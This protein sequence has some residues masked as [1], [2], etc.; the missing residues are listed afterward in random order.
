MA[1]VL[2]SAQYLMTLNSNRGLVGDST[3]GTKSAGNLPITERAQQF[4]NTTNSNA[5]GAI[6]Q[7][8]FGLTSQSSTGGFDMSADSRVI[9]T[10]VQYNAP[11]RIQSA[12]MANNGAS[13]DVVSGTNENNFKRF[14]IGGNDT[15]FCSA[16]AGAN[17]ICIDPTS[18]SN[19][20]SGGTFDDTN[21]SGWG[22][23]CVRFNV[24]GSSSLH[25]FFQRVFL[26]Q[27][28]KD[29][30]DIPK[31][32]GTGSDWDEAFT[33]VQGSSYTTTIGKW[34][35]KVGSAFFVPC[36]FQF[37]DGSTATTF[38]DGGATIVSPADNATDAENFRLTN[39]SMRVYAS[40]RNNA[41]DVLTL[42]GTYVWGT[43]SPWDFDQNDAAVINLDGATFSGMGNF[44]LGSSVSGAATFNLDS[45]SFVRSRGANLDGSQVN[46]NLDLLG[47]SATDLTNL[48][49]TGIL[50]F[51]TAGTYNL[52]ACTINEVTNSS[53]GSVILNLSNGS[54]ITTNTGPSITANNTVSLSFSNIV[55]GSRLYV[56][57]T[58]TV[59]VVTTGDVLVN[60]IVTTD[61]FV[62]AHNFEGDLSFVY[63]VRSAS[64]APYYQPVQATGTIRT[65]GF[66]AV[67]QQI[68]DE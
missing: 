25:C 56:Q 38:D 16:Q 60:Q 59:G 64:T 2:P 31:F 13:I 7:I 26:F 27:T 68:S 6:A 55:S 54:T 9:V 17:T 3:E 61:P 63:R 14:L 21:V 18:I 10:S 33:A 5:T 19:D 48:N 41:A 52:D 8:F 30:A 29:A 51:D 37:G 20:S 22:W 42:S 1:F 32:T 43:A 40:L 28:T 67:I 46:G 34:L 50:D 62:Y 36:P 15:P 44:T 53:G 24:S 49:V 65:S 47:V 58:Q 11:N 45:G 66:S 4:L 35:S 57:A 39:Q 23:G 12:T